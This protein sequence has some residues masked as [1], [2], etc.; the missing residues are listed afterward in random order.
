MKKIS[1]ATEQLKKAI[2]LLKQSHPEIGD[3]EVYYRRLAD[4]AAESLNES[5]KKQEKKTKMIIE[6]INSIYDENMRMKKVLEKHN[7]KW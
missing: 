4:E 3:V 6:S 7:L 5:N 2:A 1:N